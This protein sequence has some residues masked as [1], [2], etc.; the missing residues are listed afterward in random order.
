M[1]ASPCLWAGAFPLL[2]LLIIVNKSKHNVGRQYIA[3]INVYSVGAT[4]KNRTI[5]ENG[6]T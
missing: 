6:L 5:V 4:K 3:W 2:Y 1:S